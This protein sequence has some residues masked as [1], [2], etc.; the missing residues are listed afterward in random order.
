MKEFIEEVYNELD[1]QFK[2][3]FKGSNEV[4][5]DFCYKYIID[6]VNDSELLKQLNKHNRNLSDMTIKDFFDNNR[7]LIRAIRITLLLE[8]SKD[9]KEFQKYNKSIK[10]DKNLKD[11]DLIDFDKVLSS[12]IRISK[13]ID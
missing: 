9:F 12:I 6:S 1:V 5:D 13:K 3:K 11:N 7:V 4:F 10:S 8:L 2:A